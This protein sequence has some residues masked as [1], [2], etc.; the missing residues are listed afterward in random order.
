MLFLGNFGGE[1]NNCLL[2]SVN[3]CEH[4][5]VITS[6]PTLSSL[7]AITTPRDWLSIFVGACERFGIFVNIIC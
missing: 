4:T 1:G 3:I 2:E 7:Q 6:S 5:D